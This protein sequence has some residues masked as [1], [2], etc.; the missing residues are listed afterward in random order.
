MLYFFLVLFL[1]INTEGV[2]KDTM[3]VN[4]QATQ[5][6]VDSL[7]VQGSLQEEEPEQF[8]DNDSRKEKHGRIQ[9][10]IDLVVG[11]A[12][13]FMLILA[14][15][16]LSIQRS[17]NRAN[18]EQ[19]SQQLDEMKNA[20]NYLKSSADN[21]RATLNA[22]HEVAA[23]INR[24]IYLEKVIQRFGQL[25]FDI[26]KDTRTMYDIMINDVSAL[27]RGSLFNDNDDFRN[28]MERT[29]ANLKELETSISE[30]IKESDE[31][32]SFQQLIQESLSQAEKI[33]SGRTE[34]D[35]IVQCIEWVNGFRANMDK[36]SSGIKELIKQL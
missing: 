18:W 2:Q 17:E 8:D 14:V 10:I 6:G 1:S 20:N 3:L 12:T 32:Q 9:F 35:G 25:P 21:Q 34:I 19:T 36:V 23:S 5:I 11:F 28:A 33:I 15:C 16:Q 22:I 7:A 29:C 24:K 26:E 31:K 4:G 13:V 27:R 30:Y